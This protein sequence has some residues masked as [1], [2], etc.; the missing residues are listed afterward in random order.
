MVLNGATHLVAVYIF[1]KPISSM[2]SVASPAS[3]RPP[4][5]WPVLLSL[6]AVKFLAQLLFLHRFGIHRDE[7]LYIALGEHPAFGFWSNP[8]LIGWIS[9]LVQTLLGESVAAIRLVPLLMGCALLLL[10]GLIARELGGGRWAQGLAALA[11]LVS[12]AYLRT[13]AMFMPVIID[14]LT[15][16][17]LTYYLLRYLNTEH[18][19]YLLYFGIT[20]GLGMLNKYSVGFLLIAMLPVLIFSSYRHLL[21]DRRTGWAAL[22]ALLIMLPNLLWQYAYGFPVVHH[23]EE[24]SRNQL[25][26]VSP[27]NFMLDQLLIHAPA[28]PI[29]IMGLVWLWQQRG[30]P[31]HLLFW[32]FVSVIAVFLVFSGKSYYTLGIYPLMMA[33]G[34]LWWEQLS[35]ALLPKLIPVGF[36]LIL[37]GLLLPLSMPVLSL[38]KTVD[39]CQRQIERGLDGPMRWESGRVHP[40][41]QDYADM[42]G[43]EEIVRLVVTAYEAAPD[44]ERVM[45]Y[46]E[47]YG[48]AGAIDHF[49]PPGKLPP[50][51]SFADTYRLWAPATTQAHTL[52]YVNDELGEDVRDLFTDIRHIGEVSTPY[53]REQGTGVYLCQNPRSSFGDFWN[54]RHQMVLGEP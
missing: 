41:P 52:I 7:L 53:A 37:I 5:A 4:I 39:Y 34:G 19:R 54:E 16:T 12:P 10:T 15:W 50:V 40:L 9:G 32:L 18:Y 13:S 51:V 22:I 26:N 14:I 44:P 38:P 30:R 31:F 35:R 36:A 33:A 11:V 47:N 27:L 21:W 25:S 45:I 24:L 48:Q 49:A 6:V 42:L 1:G 28:L 2:T 3:N 23:L 17:L 8:P 29:W 46:A 20:F 43:W